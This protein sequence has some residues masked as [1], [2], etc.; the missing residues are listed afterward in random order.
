MKRIFLPM[1]NTLEARYDT[2]LQGVVH[3][4]E[5]PLHTQFSCED[6]SWESSLDRTDDP[7]E[8]HFPEKK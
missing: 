6:G 8:C 7:I 4:E 1:D 2:C 3:R 5:Y